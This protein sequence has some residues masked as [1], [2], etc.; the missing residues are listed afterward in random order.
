MT[1]HAVVT[2]TLG[3]TDLDR[4]ERFYRG[5]FGWD[6]YR[7]TP[8]YL[9][10][11]PPGGTGGGF[12]LRET[13]VAGNSCTLYVQVPE[14]TP[15]LERA[16]QLGGRVVGDVVEVPRY[17]SYRVVTDPDGNR[18][19][20]AIRPVA[21]FADDPL[22]FQPGTRYHY[23][24]PGYRLVGCALRG[25]AGKSYNT[26][27]RE[28]VFEPAGMRHTRDDDAYEIIAHRARGYVRRAGELQRSRFRDVSENLAAGGHLSTAADLVRFALAWNDGS[29]IGKASRHA[30]IAPPPDGADEGEWYG[31]GVNVK[32][33][34]DGRLILFH[35]GGLDGTR[36]LLVL[37]PREGVAVAAMTNYETIQEGLTSFANR[38]LEIVVAGDSG[39]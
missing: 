11:D 4:T 37:L 27:M 14:F 13:V 3:S 36:T 28:L 33:V 23:S 2:L 39:K 20:D 34:E 9:G 10:F 7:Q 38:A 16:E 6:L 29:L 22:L 21:R 17:A 15:Y 18:Y 31:Y 32:Q 8:T 24:S 1:A 26:L 30:M 5:M 25:A 12:L 35:T 19:D